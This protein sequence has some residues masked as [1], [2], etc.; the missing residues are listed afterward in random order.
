MLG[1]ILVAL[2][3]LALFGGGVGHRKAGLA[4]WSPAAI[5]AVI[6][7]IMLVTGRF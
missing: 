1:L 3:V 7:A 4:G 5:I 2:L 6:L